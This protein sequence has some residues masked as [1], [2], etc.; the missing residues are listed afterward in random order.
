MLDQ[1]NDAP[2]MSGDGFNIS[3]NHFSEVEENTT[4]VVFYWVIFQQK[5][6]TC[7]KINNQNSSIE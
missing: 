2:P 4:E 6:T 1:L 5:N 7:E 3:T